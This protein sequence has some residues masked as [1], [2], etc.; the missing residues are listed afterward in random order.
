MLG[1]AGKP[2]GG[3]DAAVER[4]VPQLVAEGALRDVRAAPRHQAYLAA[5]ELPARDVVGVQDHLGAAHRFAGQTQGVVAAELTPERGGEGGAVERD[6]VELRCQ[7]KDGEL[8]AR[9]ERIRTGQGDHARRQGGHGG[10]VHVVQ[11]QA[12]QGLAGEAA[13][14]L[15]GFAL[16]G[17]RPFRPDGKRLELHGLRAQLGVGQQHL[18]VGLTGHQPRDRG[19]AR[20][21]DGQLVASAAVG[22]DDGVAAVRPGGGAPTDARLQ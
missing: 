22:K 7:A 11:R 14:R 6:G 17:W 16:A 15:P 3:V 18:L 21:G 13:A 19:H 9:A 20:V 5:G 4:R 8:I 10:G 2:G 1:G 12:V